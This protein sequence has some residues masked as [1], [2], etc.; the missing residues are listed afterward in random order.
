MQVNQHVVI[1]EF[2][3]PAW[4]SERDKMNLN[5]EREYALL[6][7]LKHNSIARVIETFEEVGEKFIVIEFIMKSVDLRTLIQLRGPRK[8][9]QVERWAWKIS[10]D[11]ALC[12]R[13]ESADF[14]TETLPPTICYS[15]KAEP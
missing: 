9:R 12:A 2:A 1:K 5:F 3:I 8:E 15:T 6:R 7:T 13:S 14:F 10:G 4:V 11:H